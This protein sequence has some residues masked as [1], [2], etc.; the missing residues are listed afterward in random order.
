VVRRHPA[1]PARLARSDRLLAPVVPLVLA[2]MVAC[3]GFALD[4]IY[5]GTLL[6]RLVAGAAAGA[7]LLGVLTRRLPG[8]AAGPLSALGL[9]GY[10]LLAVRLSASATGIPGDALALAADAARNAVPRLLTALIPVEPR[11]D[12]V[13]A[14]VVAAWLAGLA[15]TELAVRGRRILLGYAAPTVCYV[16]ALYVVGPNAA[17]ARWPTVT[18]AGLA[19]LGLAAGRR[20]GDSG[21]GAADAGSDRGPGPAA[22]GGMGP[23]QDIAA[24]AGLRP[25]AAVA[26]IAGVAGATALAVVLGSVVAA[27]VDATPSDPRR[28]VAAPRL[29]TLDENPLARLSGWAVNPDQHLFDAVVDRDT[30]MRLAVLTDYDGVTWRVR[31]TYRGAGRTLPP[32]AEVP[33]G[34]QATGDSATGAHATDD[35][36]SEQVDQR[37]TIAELSGHLLPA[38]PAPRRVD[39]VRVAYDV[40]TG[41][42]ARP[43]ALT[44]GVSYRVVSERPRPDPNLLPAV[45]VPSGPAVAHLLHLAADLPE[46]IERL[47][48][49]LAEGNAG[50]YQRAAAIEAFLAEHYRFAADAPSG[51]AYPNL[52]FFLF[53]PRHAGG[54]RGTSEQFAAAFAVL[55]RAVGLPTRVVVGFQVRA[56]APTVTGRDALA[57]PEVL[58][59]GLGWV[60]FQPLPEPDGEPRPVEEDFRPKPERSTPPPSAQPTVAVSLP[61]ATSAASAPAAVTDRDGSAPPVLAASLFAVILLAAM[62]FVVAVPLLRWAQRRRRLDRGP[63]SARVAGAWLEVVD[64]LRLAGRP[65]GDH[66]TATEVAGHAAQAAAPAG[67][68]RRRVRLAAPPLDDLA[69]VV[70]A[71][72]FGPAPPGEPD[73]VWAR[74]Q[75][76]AYV[77]E[78]RSRQPWWRR[79]LWTFHPGP[80]RR[81]R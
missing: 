39:G 27:Q 46:D 1:A 3:A 15:G 10:T 11:P 4:R 40:T 74:T 54:Q 6:P 16:A 41:T 12:T 65:A 37:V 77:D 69:V 32:S 42:L 28:H 13:L 29:D 45:D 79:L 62:G 21:G 43:H 52:G 73:A 81:H 64:A 2:G 38:A 26:G 71:T 24:G 49:Q 59:T 30:R 56:G 68:P 7:V 50:P 70:N 25:R 20:P 33:D 22:D 31:A 57:W 23:Q 48:R 18:F 8:W 80:L 63:P 75:A 17:P 5:D 36:A 47:A 44:P 61:P 55:A 67:A 72:V 53:G 19:A 34:D 58:F 60:P 9:A 35:S 66:L 78:L 14:P 76:L 51:H